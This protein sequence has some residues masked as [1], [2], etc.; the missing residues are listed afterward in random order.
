MQVLPLHQ[1]FPPPEAVAQSCP[2]S[3]S[4]VLQFALSIGMVLLVLSIAWE[5]TQRLK[6]VSG[7]AFDG[8]SLAE[9][10][11]WT[12]RTILEWQ[13]LI[14]LALAVEAVLLV[15]AANFG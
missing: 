7:M 13:S 1:M 15:V 6:T 12:R 4:F 8:R 14:S 2:A 10:K 3:L 5:E 9:G 11:S